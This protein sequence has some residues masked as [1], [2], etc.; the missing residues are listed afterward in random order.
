MQIIKQEKFNKKILEVFDYEFEVQEEGLY[1]IEISARA[2]SQKQIGLNKTDDDDLRIE[3]D[4]RK[5]SKLDKKE[6]Y[7]NSPASFSGGKLHNLKKIIYF[8][9]YFSKS[10]HFIKFIPDKNPFLEEMSIKLTGDKISDINL[11]INQQAEDGDRRPWT[12]FI[13]V[14][15]PLKSLCVEATTKWR[16]KDSDDLKLIINNKI[17]E[18]KLSLFHKNWLWAGSIFK[19]LFQNET[20]SKT[21]K[22]DLQLGLHYIEFWADKMPVLYKINLDFGSPTQEKLKFGLGLVY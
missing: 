22:I 14:N 3:I 1:I 10:K 7:F 11:D 9:I 15:L 8:L 2:R 18:N 12:T 16:L 20:Q 6:G 5:F 21:I 13:L 19:K 17:Q 4:G